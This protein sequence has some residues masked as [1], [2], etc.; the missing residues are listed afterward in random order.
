[1]LISNIKSSKAEKSYNENRDIGRGWRTSRLELIENDPRFNIIARASNTSDY[2]GLLFD[3]RGLDSKKWMKIIDGNKTEGWIHI[4]SAISRLN[5]TEHEL[6]EITT[7]EELQEEA[8]KYKTVLD[9]ALEL[10]LSGEKIRESIKKIKPLNLKNG[11][12]EITNSEKKFFVTS[13]AVFAFSDEID[14]GLESTIHELKYYQKGSAIAEVDRIAKIPKEESCKLLIARSIRTLSDIYQKMDAKGKMVI[15]IEPIPI[16]I[17]DSMKKENG[18]ITIRF[19]GSLY[20]VLQKNKNEPVNIETKIF[21]IFQLLSGLAIIHDCEKVHMDIKLE[22]I[23]VDG[24]LVYLA[25]FSGAR[26]KEDVQRHFVADI[27]TAECCAYGDRVERRNCLL[28]G[29][30]DHLFGLEQK[31]DVFSMGLVL[32]RLFDPDNYPYPNYETE[33]RQVAE[34]DTISPNCKQ[35]MIE[36]INSKMREVPEEIRNIIIQML[37]PE[38]EKRISVEEALKQLTSLLSSRHFPRVN[39]LIEAQGWSLDGYSEESSSCR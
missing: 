22:N 27:F 11:A 1:M 26:S 3:R 21:Q 2:F 28:G 37:E 14:D 9:R 23:L 7:V 34:R 29:Q 18:Y 30:Y 13:D 32:Y 10:N 25:D 16:K 19:E 39:K 20:A 12:Y 17:L 31:S 4:R 38:S 35:E 8:K 24:D 15:G 5:L 6:K 33:D 36:Q